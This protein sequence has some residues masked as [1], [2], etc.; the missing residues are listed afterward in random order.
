M[1]KLIYFMGAK[2]TERTLITGWY[3][4]WVSEHF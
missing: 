4:E 1:I 2:L 3:F